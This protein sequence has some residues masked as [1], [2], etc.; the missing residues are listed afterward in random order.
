[1]LNTVRNQ[2]GCIGARLRLGFTGNLESG[3]VMRRLTPLRVA[4]AAAMA[5]VVLG[6]GGTAVAF[7]KSGGSGTGASATG[8]AL[9]LVLSPATPA[10]QLFPGGQSAV[11]LVVTN[12]DLSVIRVGSLA[13]DATQG[14]GGFAV[15]A[16]H[17]GC[18]SALGFSTQTNG[19]IG[20]N[21]PARAGAVD[22]TLSVTLA[23]A[24][25]MG[26]AAANACQGATFTVYLIRRPGPGVPAAGP[27]SPSPLVVPL[28]FCL[29]LMATLAGWD[30]PRLA[31]GGNGGAAA[32]SVGA[33]M[34][35]TGSVAGDR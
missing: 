22:G 3:P 20:W 33:G 21:V 19:G 18:T 7:W 15:D 16:G 8:D 9:P 31:R 10:T 5:L 13:L 6:Y 1:M 27:S 4:I 14:T 25:T 12:P 35:P 11:H 23:N 34:T 30:G 26:S 32:A 29:V 24:L 28:A 2:D 17:S